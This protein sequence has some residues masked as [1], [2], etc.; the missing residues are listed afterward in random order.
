[1]SSRNRVD[2]RNNREQEFPSQIWAEL[3]LVYLEDHFNEVG[4]CSHLPKANG[5]PSFRSKNLSPC[6][7][8][9]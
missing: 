1:M 3:Y 5:E 4:I 7:W 6:F 8:T 9:Y 2:A